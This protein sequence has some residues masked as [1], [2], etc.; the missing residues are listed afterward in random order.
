LKS[1][2]LGLSYKSSNDLFLGNS[3]DITYEKNF[4][5]TYTPLYT[6]EKKNKGFTFSFDAGGLFAGGYGGVGGKGYTYTDEIVNSNVSANAYG[7]LNY[8]KGRKN[9]NALIDFN[10]EKDGVFIKGRPAIAIPVSTHDYFNVTAQTGAQQFR[11]FYGGNYVVFDKRNSN[12]SSNSSFGVTMGF[13]SIIQGGGNINLTNGGSRSAKWVTNNN[14]LSTAEPNFNSTPLEEDIF[15]KQVGEKTLIDGNYFQ[16][17]GDE[18]TNRV[19]INKPADVSLAKSY[20]E[21]KYRGNDPSESVSLIKRENREKRISG[22][23]YLNA[24]QASKYGMDKKI[25]DEDRVTNDRKGHHISEITVTDNEGKRMVYGIPVYNKI[26]RDITFAV[27]KKDA[28]SY[29]QSR[30]TGLYTYTPGTDDKIANGNGRDHYYSKEEVPAYATSYL[31]TGILSQDYVDKTD[32]GISDDDPGTAVKFNYTKLPTDFQWRAPYGANTANYNEGMMSDH[33]DEKASISYGIKETWYLQSVESKTMIAIFETS[34]RDDGLGVSNEQGTPNTNVLLKKLDK[35]KLY[36]KADW[37]K[38]GANAIPVKTVLFYY[39]YSLWQGIPNCIGANPSKGKLTLKKIVFEFGKSTRGQSNPYE[40]EYDI[41]PINSQTST[42]AYSLMDPLEKDDKYTERQSDRWGTYKQSFYNR[43]KILAG[44]TIQPLLNNSE[45]PYVPQENVNTP[46]ARELANRFA[47]KWQ[48]TKIVTPSSG[49]I[50]VT[51]ESDDYAYVQNRKAMQMCFVKGVENEGQSTGLI[52]ADRLVIELPKAING[53][54]DEEKRADFKEKYLSMGGGKYHESVFYKILTNLNNT[55]GKD[56]YVH[57]Y[58][59]IDLTT[60]YFPNSTTVRLGLKKIKPEK[61]DVSYNPI[62]IEA[63]QM[64]RSDLPQYAY[65]NYDNLEVGDGEAAI[66]SIVQALKNYIGELGKPF[67]KRAAQRKFADQI[68]IEKS[69]V[70]LTNPYNAKIGGGARVKNIQI[71]DEWNVL[72]P[73]GAAAVYGQEYDY[74]I[75]DKNGIVI[76]SSGVASYEP[77]IGNEENPFHEPVNFTEKVFWGNDKY[78]FIEKPFCE[79]YF[80]AASVGYSKVTVTSFGAQNARETGRIENE[81]YTAKEFPTLVD[82]LTLD[83]K[84]YE[85]SLTVRLFSSTSI[86]NMTASQG[87]KIEL[88][89][90]HGKPKN[91]KVFNKGGDLISSTEYYYNVNDDRTETKELK[92]TVDILL[93]TGTVSSEQIGTDVDFVTDVRESVSESSGESFGA[94]IGV[95]LL[96]PFPFFFPPIPIPIAAPNYHRTSMVSSFNSISS[97][98]VVHKYGIVKKVITTQNGSTIEAENLLWD[99]E[100]GEVLL[101]R[102]QNEFDKSTY[103]FSYPA[104]M[105]GDYEGMGGAYK[106]LGAIF[107]AFQTGLNGDVTNFSAYLFPGD[108]LIALNTDKKGWIIKSGNTLRLVDKNGEFIDASGPWQVLRSGRR[109]MLTASVGSVITMNDPRVGNQVVL[110]VDK[111]ILDSKAIE[112]KEEWAIP[113]SSR[114]SSY[115]DCSSSGARMMSSPISDTVISFNKTKNGIEQI[116]TIVP[117]TS[118]KNS[119]RLSSAPESCTCNCL[120]G[121]FDYLINTNQLFIQQSQNIT[122]GQIK[123][124]ANTAGY[125]VGNCPILDNNSNKLFYALTSSAVATIYSAKIGDCTASIRSNSTNPVSF[126]GL[127]SQ[128]CT[129]SAEVNYSGNGNQ[130]VSSTFPVDCSIVTSQWEGVFSNTANTPKLVAGEYQDLSVPYSDRFVYNT[131]FRIPGISQIPTNATLTSANLFLYAHPGGFNAPLYP[132]AH[133]TLSETNGMDIMW[134]GRTQ[135]PAN[136]PCTNSYYNSWGGLTYYSSI[137]DHF[138]DV[139]VNLTF[140]VNQMI[141]ETQTWLGL[142]SLLTHNSQKNYVTFCSQTYP[143]L[144]KRPKLEVTYTVPSTI[145]NIATLSIDICNSCSDPVGQTLNPYYA[146]ILGNWRPVTNYAYTVAREQKPGNINQVGGTDIRN[147]GY[148]TAYSPFWNW[149]SGTLARTFES[150][151]TL[152][153]SDPR[154]RWIWSNRSV[155]YDQKGNEIESVDALN[156]YGAALFGYKQSV[157]TAVGANARNNEIAFDGYEDYDFD[158]ETVSSESCPLKRH[159]DFGFTK[160]GT[161]WTS[162][163]GII[164]TEQSHTGKYSYKLNGTT[165]I[166]KPAG[167]AAPS[168]TSIL[169]YDGS[170]RFLLNSNELANGFAPVNGKK[171]LFSCWVYDGSPATNTLNGVSITVNGVSPTSVTIVEGWKRVE[172]PFIASSNFNLVITGSGK[173]VDDLRIFPNDGQ[174]NSYVYDA[175]T[176]RLMAQLDENNFATLYEYDDEGT[177]VRVKKETE[178]GV[179]TLK[180]N[181]QSLRKRN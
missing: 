88:N 110:N 44:G 49:I 126:Y 55:S 99:G 177:P 94:S 171:Y 96:P 151:Q 111:R 23:S 157:A 93:P 59:E 21:F 106:N 102:T 61:S 104:Y 145:S 28:N 166:S 3:L 150:N 138:Q 58:A 1:T 149:Q 143:D 161:V 141:N 25:N 168:L 92:N 52:N 167:N 125:N 129:G 68:N 113:V 91:I 6:V 48:L 20:P 180:E 41:A 64:L 56:E 108:E 27:Q 67:E 109:N 14:F 5:Q 97:V 8:V 130:T 4:G 82:Y 95:T 160:Q 137:T 11:P 29:E 66:R 15:F 100:T 65:D 148:Y 136:G 98:K 38:N 16:K 19:V 87:F 164:S 107:S 155:Y 117:R 69:M 83:T 115:E 9:I 152:A 175:R 71:S 142:N 170:G 133:T 40:F 35:I 12:V 163:G 32:N 169:S 178:R 159:L 46:N 31:L 79:S 39:D 17:I 127:T 119:S 45:F 146:G 62:A 101:T 54:T 78:H 43:T 112:F 173:F 76:S 22:F 13:G 118:G 114:T 74:S 122:V 124:A 103:A 80:P 42:T 70:R 10:R 36:S 85:N 18:R 72:V 53:T 135:A 162:P 121:F 134:F 139:V 2:S 147:S 89:D 172:I 51:Y 77:Q 128:S 140:Q 84:P 154:S 179:M 24:W 174:M 26:Q 63:W 73:G 120:K 7:Y 60:T 90:M 75:K 50:T 86:D 33:L 57:G 153:L 131:N 132:N 144:A 158:L 37:V 116:R 105:V 165:T 47:S 30:K 156:R 81:F 181:R 176:L 123:S 34:N